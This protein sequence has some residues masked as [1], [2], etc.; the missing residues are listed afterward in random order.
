MHGDG[1]GAR[2]VDVSVD[3]ASSR[4]AVLSKIAPAAIWDPVTGTALDPVTGL[5]FS[6]YTIEASGP[7]LEPE[8]AVETPAEHDARVAKDKLFADLL[9]G[10]MARLGATKPPSSEAAPPPDAEHPREER[11][12]EEPS[13]EEAA[14]PSPSTDAFDAVRYNLAG[15][16]AYRA[17]H[18]L[19]ALS[20]DDKLS[21]F[22]LEGS[23]ET[24]A[25]HKPHTHFIR[26]ISSSLGKKSLTGFSSMGAE[27]QGDQNGMALYDADPI[28]NTKKQID[29]AL[30]MMHDEG[31][32]GGHYDTM[33]NPKLRRVGIGLFN[34]PWSRLY[35]TNDFSD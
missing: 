24:L 12:K 3:P 7:A 6:P 31:P 13:K 35:M 1:L 20:L 17:L 15:L 4:P 16:N 26:E 29:L 33:L 25:T 2:P 11:P 14:P 23:K 19:A 9:V 27:N 30:K 21:E 10:A 5:T 18:S 28:I 34:D 8:V 32:G 22:A